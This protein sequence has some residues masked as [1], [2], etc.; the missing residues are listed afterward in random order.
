MSVQQIVLSD[1][2]RTILN[3]QGDRISKEVHE[4]CK[5]RCKEIIQTLEITEKTINVAIKIMADEIF[6]YQT[7]YYH[8]LVLLSFCIE[9]DKQCKLKRF[10]WYSKEVLVKTIVDILC[11]VNFIPPPPFVSSSSS[12]YNTCIII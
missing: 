11:D 6:L 2:V 12:S 8:V 5:E 9:L 4:E 3:Q 10:E 7:K 1:F